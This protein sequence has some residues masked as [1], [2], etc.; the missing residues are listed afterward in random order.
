MSKSHSFKVILGGAVVVLLAG[1]LLFSGKEVSGAATY[2]NLEQRY[3]IQYPKSWSVDASKNLESPSQV[4]FISPEKKS[5][6]NSNLAGDLFPYDVAVIAWST[7]QSLQEFLKPQTESPDAADVRTI[8]INGL[9]GY[10]STSGANHAFYFKRGNMIF[11]IDMASDNFT[12][13][14]QRLQI[15]QSFTFTK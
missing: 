11:Q 10:E 15:A 8:S 1:Y 14:E 9:D 6:L 5:A 7:K 12:F 4:Y 13:P 3:A 2:T